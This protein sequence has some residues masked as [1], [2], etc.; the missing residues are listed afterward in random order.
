MDTYTRF[1]LEEFTKHR[2]IPISAQ[3]HVLRGCWEKHE[4]KY[5]NAVVKASLTSHP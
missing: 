2:S 3:H 4:P 1:G 5:N